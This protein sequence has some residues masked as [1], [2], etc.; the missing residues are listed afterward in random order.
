MHAYLMEVA[1]FQP[2]KSC[3][4]LKTQ[5]SS[6]GPSLRKQFH[7]WRKTSRSDQPNSE[8]H[9]EI[10]EEHLTS[11]TAYDIRSSRRSAVPQEEKSG[12][13]GQTITSK[14]RSLTYQ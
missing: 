11:I 7:D 12:S 4:L 10:P 9:P 3:N 2:R 5:N 14:H 1:S 13:P 6:R 8:P